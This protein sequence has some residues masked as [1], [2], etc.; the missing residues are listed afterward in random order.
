MFI[1][2]MKLVVTPLLLW[3]TTL[4]T[5]RWGTLVGGWIVGLPLTS[6]PVS[7]FLAIE[8]GRDFAAASA[9][10]TLHG[11]LAVVMFCFVYD[12][13][14]R[15]FSWPLAAATSL[16]AY[17]AI[18]AF[19]AAV[20]PPLWISVILVF[21]V[22]TAGVVLVEAV[23]D[24]KSVTVAPAWDLPLRMITATTIVVTI[25][26]I[27]QSLGPYMSGM[28]AAFPV[29]ICVMSVFSHY[30]NGA[31]AVRNFER[32]VIVG[33]YAFTVFF[34]VVVFTVRTWNL[35]LVYSVAIL[36]AMVTNLVVYRVLAM[37]RRR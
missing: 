34:L 18:V 26:T 32:G 10:S 7:V 9:H 30:L 14:A 22:V 8:Q 24:V 37:V 13:C 36:C 15:R 33:S 20:I 4:A 29:F 5:R 31:A 25:T 6:G 16:A 1:T 2:V 28:L 19:F 17:F 23:P 3:G 21:V 27:S 35:A 12:R 11:L